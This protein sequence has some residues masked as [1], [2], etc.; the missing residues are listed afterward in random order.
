MA[1]INDESIVAG[2]RLLGSIADFVRACET[3][4]VEEQD[5]PSPNNALI[6]TLCDAV[7]LAREYCDH[8]TGLSTP[9]DP[10]G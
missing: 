3:H 9:K 8:A 10:S 7:R 5:M 2:S 1:D 6:A 4:I